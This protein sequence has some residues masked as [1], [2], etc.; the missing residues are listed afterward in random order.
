MGKLRLSG[1]VKESIVDGPG[2]RLT[3]FSQ[4]CRHNCIGCHNP[5]THSFTGGYE[6]T[7]ENILDMIKANPLL[8][9]VTFS[10]GDPFEQAE[11]FAVLGR[12]I[13]EL[14]LDIITYTGY[15]YE[16]IIEK[17]KEVQGWKDLLEVTDILIDGVFIEGQ[18]SLELKYRGSR[19]QRIIDV[20]KTMA[21]GEII[22]IAE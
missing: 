2:I 22:V 16:V 14:G 18:R 4:G 17:G 13:K 8:D 3:V 9:G 5:H 6:E 12:K 7:I 21:Q 20:K 1:I 11:L 19:N 10:G 15:T